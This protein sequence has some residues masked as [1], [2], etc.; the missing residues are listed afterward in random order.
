MVGGVRSRLQ[1]SIRVLYCQS[2]PHPEYHYIVQVQQS[3]PCFNCYIVSAWVDSRR[4]GESSDY[5]NQIVTYAQK[6]SKGV[7]HSRSVSLTK[8]DAL[9]KAAEGVVPINTKRST[10]AVFV[11]WLNMLE[12]CAIFIMLLQ[13]VVYWSCDSPK[14]SRLVMWLP[15]VF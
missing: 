13:S 10:V 2:K 6:P 14:C 15:Q 8:P 5:E 1:Y 3:P 7:K 11:V 4:D 9:T 12:K